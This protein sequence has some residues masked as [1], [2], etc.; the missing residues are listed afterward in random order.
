MRSAGGEGLDVFRFHANAQKG[1]DG[2]RGMG[3]V[4]ESRR[5]NTAHR[6]KS[7]ILTLC[8]S[9]SGYRRIGRTR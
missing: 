8:G 6:L 5:G 4:F 9:K 3:T 7:P 2:I 1:V